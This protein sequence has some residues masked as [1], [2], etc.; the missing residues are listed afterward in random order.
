MSRAGRSTPHSVAVFGLW[1]C[2]L[3]CAAWAAVR[4][5]GLESGSPSVQ[6][7]AYTSLLGV[8]TSTLNLAPEHRETEQLLA[9]W[10]A[11]ERRF[12]IPWGSGAS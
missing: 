6:L 1:V 12:L 7:I 9:E 3:A 5:L 8:E 4:T 11:V 10:A 2:L